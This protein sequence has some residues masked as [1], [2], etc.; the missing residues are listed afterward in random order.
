MDF[1]EIGELSD[2]E[3]I[4]I[5]RSEEQKLLAVTSASVA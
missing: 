5:N 4:A 1:E 3:T 2:V